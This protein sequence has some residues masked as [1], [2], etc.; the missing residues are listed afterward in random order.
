MEPIQIDTLLYHNREIEQNILGSILKEPKLITKCIEAIEFDDFYETKHQKIYTTLIE[1]YMDD[2]S[3]D[4]TTI[5]GTLG[6][7]V[8][9]VGGI[10]YLTELKASVVDCTPLKYWLEILKDKSDRRQIMRFAQ[11]LNANSKI[12][13]N[14]DDLIQAIQGFN[15]KAKS[16]EDSGEVEEALEQVLNEVETA[17]KNGGQIAGIP[18]QLIELDNKINGL[19]KQQLIILAGRPAMGK[20]TVANNIL[21]NLIDQDKK[22]ALF[23]LEM[24]KSQ[25]YKKLLAAKGKIK[26]NNIKTGKMEDKD[27][28]KFNEAQSQFYSKRN[29]CKIYD[30]IFRLNGI[31]A[32][33]KELK[34]K[35]KLDV[36]IVDYLQLIDPQKKCGSREQEVSHISRT[37]KL[38]SKEL[39][40]TVICLSQLSRAVEQRADKRPMLS[41]LRESGAIEQDADVIMFCY[42]DEYYNVET[43]D[44]NIVEIVIGKQREGETGNIKLAWL[45]EYQIVGNLYKG[46]I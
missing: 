22:V 18:T 28:V 27:W 44:K 2:K 13:K 5:Y 29:N 19:S 6:A 24:S 36:M 12:E 40:I 43:E 8:T 3:I 20:S 39:D 1:M 34:L 30:K 16:D 26:F 11:E 38:L 23:N 14:N 45:P 9:N 17:F 42:R 4:L 46:E 7:E 32:K 37:L 25:I 31:K 41:D 35:N 10:S 33:A 21:I 15:L